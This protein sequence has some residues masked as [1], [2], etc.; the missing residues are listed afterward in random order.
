M[1]TSS[2]G[3]ISFRRALSG[4]QGYDKTTIQ[5][6]ESSLLEIIVRQS[7]LLIPNH[8]V[9]TS[10]GLNSSPR[11]DRNRP[12]WHASRFECRRRSASL[13]HIH[14]PDTRLYEKVRS[15]LRKLHHLDDALPVVLSEVKGL[16]VG[17]GA[18]AGLQ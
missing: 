5:P 13:R 8:K 6:S 4:W 1:R 16:A 10:L 11:F 15:L 17:G 2:E 9:F 7:T 3:M 18:E 12:N 14:S